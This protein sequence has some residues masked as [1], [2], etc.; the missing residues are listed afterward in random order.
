MTANS[1]V[2]FERTL[3]ENN[4]RRKFIKIYEKMYFKCKLNLNK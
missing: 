3:F 2:K 1:N 4:F